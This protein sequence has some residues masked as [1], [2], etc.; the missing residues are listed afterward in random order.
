MGPP[1]RRRWFPSDGATPQRGREVPQFEPI[2]SLFTSQI[3]WLVIMFAI[4]YRIVTKLILPRMTATLELRQRTVAGNLERAET[5]KAEAEAVL[6]GYEQALADARTQAHE[7]LRAAQDAISEEIAQRER[8]QA[9]V[10]GEQIEA[11]E[12]RI[13]AAAVAATDA[14]GEAVAEVTAELVNQIS[15][16]KPTEK[17]VA[18]AVKSAQSV[19]A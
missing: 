13:A 3:F 1:A 6:A 5:A 14:I 4:L 11:A 18:D 12:K 8:A 9:E 19:S 15:G 16:K 2:E 10:V 7:T 17:Q